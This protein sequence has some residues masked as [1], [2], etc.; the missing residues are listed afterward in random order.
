MSR[1][2]KMKFL[3]NRIDLLRS[4]DAVGNAKLIAKLERELRNL[5]K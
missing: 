5:S 3:A 4:R 2:L 1:E